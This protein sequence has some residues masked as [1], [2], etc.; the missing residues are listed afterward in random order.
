MSI[1]TPRGRTINPTV[2]YTSAFL[3][4]VLVLFASIFPKTADNHF[5]QVQSWIVGHVS[6]F[7]VLTVAIILLSA[8]YLA[9]SRYGDIKLGP[10]HSRPD[11]KNISWF[12]MLFSAGTGIG[13]M[14]FGVAESNLRPIYALTL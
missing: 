3:I 14:F 4:T 8:V 2:F 6:W 5:N 1:P 7:Y 11:Y 10:D 9:F 13:L 12:A